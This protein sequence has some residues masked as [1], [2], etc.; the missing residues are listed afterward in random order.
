M[1]VLACSLPTCSLSTM[2]IVFVPFSFIVCSFFLL[3][4]C[5]ILKDRPQELDGDH[6]PCKLLRNQKF[7]SPHDKAVM[8]EGATD[9]SDLQCKILFC[10]VDHLRP[11]FVHL[12]DRNSLAVTWVCAARNGSPEYSTWWQVRAQIFRLMQSSIW[13]IISLDAASLERS[14]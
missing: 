5:W 13:R 14:F 10:P 1:K 7:N 8:W 9:A 3:T 6:F 2:L 12:V 4:D 11:L